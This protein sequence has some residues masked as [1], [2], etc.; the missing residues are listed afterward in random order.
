MD[1]SRE[2]VFGEVDIDRRRIQGLMSKKGLDGK[3]VN[4]AFIEMCSQGVAE[5]VT[6]DAV[7]P[8]QFLLVF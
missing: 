3:K 4:A 7:R 5:S 2:T 1:N 6:G 8:A